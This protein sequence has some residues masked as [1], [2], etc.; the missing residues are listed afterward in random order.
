MMTARVEMTVVLR[1]G[2]APLVT[3]G[4]LCRKLAAVRM[5]MMLMRET[6]VI[7]DDGLY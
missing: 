1:H 3:E 2:G 6:L 4:G 7:D 5:M